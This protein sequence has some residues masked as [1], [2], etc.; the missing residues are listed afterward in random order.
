MRID[1]IAPRFTSIV[2]GREVK[3]VSAVHA[4]KPVAINAYEVQ[5]GALHKL[6]QPVVQEK[7]TS[8][9]QR[10]ELEERRKMCRRVKQQAVLIE[11]RSGIDRRRHNL[12]DSDLHE[13]IDEE[14]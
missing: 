8:P 10:V 11:L 2:S 13:H 1:S 7:F 14:A 9:Q 12:R 6:T 4:V 3:S 5:G